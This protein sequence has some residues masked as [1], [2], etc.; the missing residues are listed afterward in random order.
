M[1]EH[2]IRDVARFF[3]EH[4]PWL[5][6]TGAGISTESG[7]P[8]FRTPSSGLWARYDPMEILSREVLFS[9]PE[10]FYG[11]GLK[12]LL[13]FHEAQPNEAHLVLAEWERRGWIVGVV[14]QNID[15][16]H[17][18][19]GS[20]NVMEIHGH[21]RSGSCLRC[22]RSVPIEVLVEKTNQGEIPPRCECGGIL[23]PDVVLFGDT[24]PPC[25]EEAVLLS[26]RY[27]L[28]VIGSSLQVSP[29]NFLPTYAPHLVIVN[30]GETP[31]DNRAQWVLRERASVALRRLH[32]AIEE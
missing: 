18:K 31:F 15:S 24:L 30:I 28:L 4:A 32:E 1:D 25:F 29:A 6:L 22:G 7:I 10:V 3:R 19:A 20:K 12:V 8:D 17:T 16:L 13:S 14:T 11:V 23:R 9:K 26:H 2:L 27:P 21:L 5:V